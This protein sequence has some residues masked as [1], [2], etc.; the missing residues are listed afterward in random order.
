MTFLDA[1]ILWSLNKVKNERTIYS[2]YHLLKGKKSSQTIQD[3]HIFQLGHLFQTYPFL[4]REAYAAIIKNL[5]KQMLLEENDSHALLTQKGLDQIKVFFLHHPFPKQINGLKYQDTANLLWKRL[6][7][8]IQVMSNLVNNENHYYPIQRDEALLRWMKGFLQNKALPK[9]ELSGQ[10]YK[11]LTNF[12]SENPP[13][14]PEILVIRLTGYQH[15]GKTMK[16]ASEYLNMEESEYWYRFL[17][18]LHSLIQKVTETPDQYLIL[19]KVIAD[20]YQEIAWTRSTQKTYDLLKK[21]YTVSEI[22][23]MRNLKT[24]TIEDHIIEIALNEPEFQIDMYL[25]KKMEQNIFLASQTLGLKR[26]KPIKEAVK[27]AS[28]FQIR[29]ALAKRGQIHEHATST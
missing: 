7:L 20:S 4:S 14:D 11:E 24:S 23:E 3:A 19:H 21:Q 1:V 9:E 5:R 17:H 12:L 18:L 8:T 15:I 13:E 28:Y 16:Q 29:L 2:I 6:S 22:A 25:D 10:L 27:N 26:L